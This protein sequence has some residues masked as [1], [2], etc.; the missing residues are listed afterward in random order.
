MRGKNLLSDKAIRAALKSAAEAGKVVTV[1]DGAGL[2]LEAQSSGQVGWWRVRYWVDGKA[3]RL[4]VGVYPDVSLSAARERRDQTR[5]LVAA[6]ADPSED[7]KAEKAARTQK[8]L[9]R[10]LEAEGKPGPGTFEFVAREWLTTVHSAKVSPGHA[11]RTR[12]RL[13]QDAFPWIG[14]RPIDAIEAPDLL[15]ALRRVEARGAIETAHRV[16]DAC[17]QVF[18]YGIAIGACKRNPAA[19]L[20][21][22]LRPV[23]TKHHAAITDPKQVG[24]L[25]RAMADYQGHPVTRAALGLSAL[26]LLRP[27]ELRHMEWAWLDLGN[28]LLTVPPEVMKRSKAD[29]VNGAPHVVPLAPQAVAILRDLQPLTGSGRFVFPAL[30]SSQRCMSDNTVRSALRRMGYGNDDMTAH[31]FRATARTMIAER[32]GIAP[33]V[34]E[35]QLAHAVADSLGRAYNRTQY[36]D[37]RR[38]MMGQWADYLDRLRV[39]AQIIPLPDRAA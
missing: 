25:L 18:R 17:G 22:A 19:D 11:E 21:D 15:E 20:K 26:L 12:I 16:K 10:K 14:R 32:L 28:G 23:E 27:G 1:N 35:A 2:T 37:Q 9:A 6:G 38:E 24:D 34:I 4:S 33:E 31:G 5:E 3:N 13:E 29:K 8:A 30:T 7:R 39:G 36:L